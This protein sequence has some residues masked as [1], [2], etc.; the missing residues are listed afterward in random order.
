MGQSSL[1]ETTIE[2]SGHPVK[3]ETG[4]RKNYSHREIQY[5]FLPLFILGGASCG[6]HAEQSR[7]AF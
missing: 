2:K 7:H 3:K 6:T 1:N 5:F 4:Q